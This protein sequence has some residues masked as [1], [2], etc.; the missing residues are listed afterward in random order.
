MIT[1]YMHKGTFNDSYA[2]FILEFFYL[3]TRQFS[4]NFSKK[5]LTL[6]YLFHM[7]VLLLKKGKEDSENTLK[8]P[9]LI[10]V[11]KR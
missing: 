7:I 4:Q 1:F 11:V 3:K 2:Y 6:D 8:A 5:I 10:C 9:E